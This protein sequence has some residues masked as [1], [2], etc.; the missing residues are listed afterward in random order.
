M[1]Q[2]KPDREIIFDTESTGWAEEGQRLLEIGCVELVNRVPTGKTWQTYLNPEREI[3]WQSQRIHG[4]TNEKVADAPKFA[5]IAAQLLAFIADSPL[6]AHNAE[7]DITFLNMELA[8]CKL[9]PVANPVVDSLA[10]ARQKLPGQRCSL[11]ALCSFYNVDTSARVVH[12]ALID[13]QLLAEVYIELTGGRQ[14][15]LLADIPAVPSSPSIPS[16]SFTTNDQRP[17]TDGLILASTSDERAV[18]QAFLQ[19]CIPNA[20]W[21]ADENSQ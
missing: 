12:G 1:Q 8:R 6:V 15:N 2:E 5:D 17:T 18:H 4:I 7:F 14:G 21:P 11:D 20:T 3:D 16:S 13:A 9:P 19:K 10:I